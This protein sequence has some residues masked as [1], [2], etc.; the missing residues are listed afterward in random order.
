MLPFERMHP[1]AASQ[2]CSQWLP[3]GIFVAMMAGPFVKRSDRIQ[4]DRTSASI[5][6]R[7][8]LHG[9]SSWLSRLLLNS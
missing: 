6:L 8:V 2:I 7:V 3:R 1:R 4:E 5:C 9:I